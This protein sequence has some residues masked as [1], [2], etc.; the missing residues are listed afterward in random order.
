[1]NR[2][3]FIR[4]ATGALL[5]PAFPAIVRA[6]TPQQRAA[7]MAPRPKPVVASFVN[8]A[9]VSGLK[10]WLKADVGVYSDSGVTPCTNTD[11]C[12]QWNDQSGNVGNATQSNATK[13]AKWYS[14]SGRP[15]LKFYGAEDYNLPVSLSAGSVTLF[16]AI[17]I[18]DATSIVTYLI[19]S[20]TGRF[21]FALV[22]GTSQQTGWYDTNITWRSFGTITNGWHTLIW[23]LENTQTSYVYLDG[24]PLGAGAIYNSTAIGGATTLGSKYD[25]SASWMYAN[26]GELGLYNSALSSVDLASLQSYLKARW[27]TP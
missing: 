16:C 23:W 7:I 12:S 13:K 9:S 20:A 5:I 1:M 10:L 22:S 27:S 6:I 15:V 26:L 4:S 18:V 3:A 24:A 25:E 11:A 17:E 19:D 2:R 8:P 14:N 21:I